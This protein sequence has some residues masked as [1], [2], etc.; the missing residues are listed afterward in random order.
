[1]KLIRNAIQTPDGTILESLHRHDYK[2]YTDANGKEYMVDGGRD[3]V[4]RSTW[5]DEIDLCVYYNDV[6]HEV[7]RNTIKWGS[8]G[9]NGD[10]PP[11]FKTIARMDCDHIRNVLDY[12]KNVDPIV[13]ECMIQE[14]KHR[15]VQWSDWGN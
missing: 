6:S 7:Q 1:M 5:G 11:T 3:Y 12:C 15:G 8:Y 2:T 9:I 10:Q 13:R 4:R 14:L